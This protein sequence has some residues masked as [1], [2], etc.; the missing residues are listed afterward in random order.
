[1]CGRYAFYAP[2]EAVA[3]LFGVRIAEALTPRYNIAPTQRVPVVRI[4]GAG[5]RHV[6][7]LYWG[8]IPHWAKDRS[9]GARMI[10]A[11]AETIAQ[12]PAFRQALRRRRCLVLANGW[13]EWQTTAGGKQPWF[14]S[15]ADGE[16]CAF[17]GLWESWSPAP[18][19][20]PLESCAIVTTEA[21]GFLATLH[22]RMPV[23]LARENYDVWLRG[24]HPASAV[25]EAG[26][27]TLLAL[28]QPPPE[29]TL[30]AWRVSRR[31]N[32]VRHDGPELIEK[33]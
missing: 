13:Y 8:L 30:R 14:V 29:G 32:H 16:P 27:A 23:V 25:S 20:P 28:L 18:H 17:A 10:N 7:Q 21:R 33:Q 24:D 6:D 4:D 3:R 1:M 22:T 12:K 31:V 15:A 9:I 26:V 11:R 5:V 19:E 2:A